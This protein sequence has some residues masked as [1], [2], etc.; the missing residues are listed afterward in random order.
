VSGLK[1]LRGPWLTT[2]VNDL[3]DRLLIGHGSWLPRFAE[4]S[5][6][7]ADPF[8]VGVHFDGTAPARSRTCPSPSRSEDGL[9]GTRR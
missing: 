5:L 9:D 7:L 2:A 6:E 4:S 8:G 3:P 1:A